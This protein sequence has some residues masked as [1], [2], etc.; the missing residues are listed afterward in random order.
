MQ[1]DR[2]QTEIANLSAMSDADNFMNSIQQK[3]L[4]IT[5]LQS[6]Q[7]A[8]FPTE[9]RIK[10]L[11]YN[12]QT[13]EQELHKN[14]SAITLIQTRNNAIQQQMTQHQTQLKA[15]QEQMQLQKLQQAGATP[16]SLVIPPQTVNAH[17]H[18]FAKLVAVG[19]RQATNGDSEVAQLMAG[20][21]LEVD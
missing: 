12:I 4:Q 10:E 13:L 19:Q 2:L 17:Y 20:L 18:T 5:D 16:G 9:V 11:Q 8:L 6:Q 1:V 15:L 21:A 3:Q 7:N 14:T